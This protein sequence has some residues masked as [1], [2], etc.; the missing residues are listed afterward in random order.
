MSALLEQLEQQA[1]TL[2]PDERAHLAEA[3]LESLSARTPEV[4]AAWREEIEKRVAA[5]ECGDTQTYP[6]EE[7]LAEARRATP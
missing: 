5:Y 1:F 3:L 2:A 7:V 4:G 6:A